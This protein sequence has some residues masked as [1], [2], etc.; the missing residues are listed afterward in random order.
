LLNHNLLSR[1]KLVNGF[2][3]RPSVKPIFAAQHPDQFKNGDQPNP[4][5][6]INRE[7]SQDLIRFRALERVVLQ[8]ESRENVCVEASQ[9]ASPSG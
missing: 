5:R 3:N 2:C 1:K 9:A 6:T 8:E 7:R 4:T